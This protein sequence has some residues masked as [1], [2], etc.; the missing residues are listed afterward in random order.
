MLSCPITVLRYADGEDRKCVPVC[1]NHTIN[2]SSVQ[3]YADNS[4][5][6]CV[7]S[8]PETPDKFYGY[9]LTNLCL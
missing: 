9:N 8:C 3:F 6:S 5:M 7:R 2:G 4:T 1:S